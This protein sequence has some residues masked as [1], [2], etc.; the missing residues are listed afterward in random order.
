MLFRILFSYAQNISRAL[1]Q[2]RTC[3]SGFASGTAFP[4]AALLL[5][6]EYIHMSKKILSESHAPKEHSEAYAM[7]KWFMAHK[8]TDQAIKQ[9]E[10][11]IEKSFEDQ[12]S[13]R[14][15]LSLLYKKQLLQQ[16]TCTSGF[17]SGTAFPKAALLLPSDFVF[18]TGAINP[19]VHC[20]GPQTIFL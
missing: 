20:P 4:K 15:D 5:P 1:L 16:R 13:A 14:L 9:L 10:R 17:A 18:C 19:A 3:T 7:A 6:S 12:D 8:E 11:L 2:Q